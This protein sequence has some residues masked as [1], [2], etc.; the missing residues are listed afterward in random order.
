MR[1]STGVYYEKLDHVR[2]LAAFLVF[3][4]HFVH[5]SN[6]VPFKVVPAFALFS[7]FEDGHTGVA[8]FM[9]LSGY[10][11][12]KLIDDRDIDYGA[13]LWNRFVRLAPLLIVV[14]VVTY[15]LQMYHGQPFYEV[16]KAFIAGFVIPIW[17]NGGW[18]LTVEVHFYLV[19][20]FL[21][22]MVRHRA[23]AA[24]YVVLAMLA[25]RYL[26]YVEIG[27]IQDLAYWTIVGRVDQFTL[28]IFAFYAGRTA[29]PGRPI[30]LLAAAS[31]LVFFHAFNVQGGFYGNEGYPSR[32]PIWIVMPAIEGA[33]YSLMIWSYDKADWS[34]PAGLS[35][36]VSFVGKI[37]YSI[38]LIHFFVVF[39]LADAFVLH[40]VSAPSYEMMFLA[41]F[42]AFILILP[43]AWLSHRFIEGAFMRFRTTYIRD[44]T[45]PAREDEKPASA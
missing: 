35:R 6:I 36:V 34:L 39:R 10:I 1:A 33:F 37:S 5:T 23:D 44:L 25:V 12:A 24:L 13:F 32:D 8:L 18:S 28:G 43:F 22:R 26:L 15:A 19:L 11:F 3:T 40:V 20:P 14:L 29:R 45:L 27:Q 16:L 41:S 4:W 9:T 7:F 31:F 17:P 30:V 38:Y 21:L 2:A 42:G